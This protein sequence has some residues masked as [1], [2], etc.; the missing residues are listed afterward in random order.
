MLINFFWKLRSYQKIRRR[1][2]ELQEK[3][4][5]IRENGKSIPVSLSTSVT[6]QAAEHKSASTCALAF[7][8]KLPRPLQ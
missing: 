2:K 1:L 4:Y 8:N 6:L 3:V 7:I 5:A